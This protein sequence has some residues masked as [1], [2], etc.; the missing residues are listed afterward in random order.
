[1]PT[2]GEIGIT[3]VEKSSTQE[4]FISFLYQFMRINNTYR[5]EFCVEQ[6]TQMPT[7]YDN[8]VNSEYSVDNIEA[9]IAGVTAELYKFGALY[10]SCYLASQ[11]TQRIMRW[12]DTSQKNPDRVLARVYQYNLDIVAAIAGLYVSYVEQSSE[13]IGIY[14]AK[15]IEGLFGPVGEELPDGLDICLIVSTYF[16]T[17]DWCGEEY[18][19]LNKNDAKKFI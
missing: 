12:V 18:A 1:M 15:L 17:P 9:D 8:I 7:W 16:F 5:L 13:N 11:D 2:V 6:L 10:Q 19:N 4:T 3:L 14:F